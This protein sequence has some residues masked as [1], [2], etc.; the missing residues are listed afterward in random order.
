MIFGSGGRKGGGEGMRK[1]TS[2]RRR[3]KRSGGVWQLRSIC[4]GIGS[5]DV[6]GL[7]ICF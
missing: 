5:C 3:K 6:L 2:K 1:E 4:L 7:G